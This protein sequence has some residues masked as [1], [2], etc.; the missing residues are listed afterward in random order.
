MSETQ[1][2]LTEADKLARIADSVSGAYATELARVLRDLERELRR[3][4]LDALNG[5][6]TALGRA[7]RAA[8]LRKEVQKALE[9]AGY[10]RLAVTTTARSLERL[11]A[12][13]EALRG[14]AKLAAFTT[15]DQTRILALKELAKIDLLGEGADMAHALWRTLAQS[16][17]AQRKPADLLDDLQ[18]A[19][20][21]EEARA[22]TLFD[23]TVSVFTRQVEMM[24]S[25]GEPD[26]PFA[27][28]GP[29][30]MKIRPFCRAHVGR[31]YTRA[32]IDDMDN[33]QIPNVFLTGGGYNCRHV[34]Q[35]VSKFSE[36]RD[37]TGTT[38]RI[39]EVA[40]ALARVPVGGSRAA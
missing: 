18:T 38:E 3:L 16:L 15:T 7:V 31:V 33:G 19:M 27:Y 28:V 5:S 40:D 25:N 20:D 26:E 39:P 10:G 17:Y 1:A 8:K 36:L 37:L 34:W 2:L 35:A 21:L 23:T 29:V 14:A 32:E 11:I 13:V 24:K 30:D 9:T 4:A 6:Q 22:R 12:Q